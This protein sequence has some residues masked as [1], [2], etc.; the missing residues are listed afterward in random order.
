[1]NGTLDWGQRPLSA[2][3]ITNLH[4]EKATKKS[5]HLLQQ[6][7]SVEPRVTAE[8][9]AALPPSASP[10]Q[11]DKRVKSPES[12]ARKLQ[13][14]SAKRR[15]VPLDDLLRY[16][17]LTASPDDL[18]TAARQTIERL[19]DQDWGVVYA[20]HSY[21]DGS[22]YKGLHAY[23]TVAGVNRLE[24]QFHSVDSAKV[25]E[26]TTPWYEIERDANASD[27]D[28]TIAR[29]RCVDLSATLSSP[30]DIDNLTMLGGRPVAVH[31][32]SDSREEQPPPER[33]STDAPAPAENMRML[34]RNNGMMR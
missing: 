27:E 5:L 26:L 23:L 17:A 8:F 25:K 1:V 18:V 32:Y 30:N 24:V 14:I 21:T 13:N 34:K 3:D 7:V 19:I 16:T 33:L 29:Q 31:N 10:Y 9:L 15:R 20:M 22:R 28:R 4:G 11:L 12:L 6:T 2:A